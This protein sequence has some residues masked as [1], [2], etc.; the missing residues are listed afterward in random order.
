MERWARPMEVFFE[1][2]PEGDRMRD[3]LA[4]ETSMIYKCMRIYDSK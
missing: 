3:L 4:N 1:V 2:I